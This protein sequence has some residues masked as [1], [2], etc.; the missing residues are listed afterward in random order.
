M[1]EW[2][3]AEKEPKKVIRL[4]MILISSIDWPAKLI[5][6]RTQMLACVDLAS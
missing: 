2:E 1:S 3:Y 4:K 5:F 6:V